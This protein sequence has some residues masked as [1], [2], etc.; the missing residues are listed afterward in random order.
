MIDFDHLVIAGPNL[1][2]LVVLVEEATG[3]RSIPGGPHIGLGT[4][5]ELIGVGPTTYIE[6]IGPDP[7][8]PEPAG[9]RPFGI[10]DLTEPTLVTWAVA[11]EDME[12]AQA[13]VAAAGIDPGESFP[14]SRV[15]PDGVTLSWHLSIPPA[16]ELGGIVPFIIG[17]GADTPHPAAALAAELEI[18]SLGLSH[19]DPG[20]IATAI[21]GITTGSVDIKTE[22]PGMN[23]T[24]RGPNGDLDL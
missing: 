4:T 14:M 12:T 13:A 16:P 18:V 11:V 17:W 3:V 2:E 5:N 9:P 23:V 10:D 19:P 22:Q 20:P 7:D 15:R 24:L 6:L 21:A 8:Q 1:A